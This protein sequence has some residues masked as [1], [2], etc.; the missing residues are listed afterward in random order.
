MSRDQTH[1]FIALVPKLNGSHTAHQFRPISFCNIVYKIISKIL[2]NR[3][4][5]HLHKI[6]SPLQS[7]FVPK[8]NIQDNTILA[9]E[10]LHSFKSKR[11]KGGYM[12]LKMDTEKVF[13]RMKWTFLLD[14]L[15]KLGFSLIWIS[16]IRTCISSASFS[17]LLNGSLFGH[18][19]PEKGLRQG[20]PLP[21]FLF[22]LSSKVFSRLLFKEE[23]KDCINGLRIARNC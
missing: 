8:R 18:I 7:A 20:D 13:D 10:L 6:I 16:Q 9:H 12:F 23:R 1:S 22:I 2:A 14:I 19:S 3:L 17:I 21:P 4:K 5:V 15:E 11:G